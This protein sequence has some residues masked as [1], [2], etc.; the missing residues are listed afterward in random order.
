MHNPKSPMLLFAGVINDIK[1]A[2]LDK[3]CFKNEIC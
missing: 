1:M 3:N 2:I